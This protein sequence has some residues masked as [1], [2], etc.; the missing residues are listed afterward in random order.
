VEWQEIAIRITEDR[1]P[2]YLEQ[3]QALAFPGL[4]EA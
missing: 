1:N 3:A 4:L 2:Q